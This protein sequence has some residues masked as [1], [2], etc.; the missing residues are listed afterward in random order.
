ME[1]QNIYMINSKESGKGGT[2][3]ELTDGTNKK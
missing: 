1:F 2:E 3:G